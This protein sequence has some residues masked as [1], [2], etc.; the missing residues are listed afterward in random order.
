[1]KSSLENIYDFQKYI[2]SVGF[3]KRLIEENNIPDTTEILVERISEDY[4]DT[5]NWLVI[6]MKDPVISGEIVNL[7]TPHTI[8]YSP[9]LKKVIIWIHS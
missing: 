5:N 6:Q 8:T 4:L 3:F 9:E 1:M 2:R 7:I